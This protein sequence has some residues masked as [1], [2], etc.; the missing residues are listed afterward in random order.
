MANA[1]LAPQLLE[2]PDAV[3]APGSLTAASGGGISPW[4]NCPWVSG[5]RINPIN[6]TTIRA[7]TTV[8]AIAMLPPNQLV[9]D[10]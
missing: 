3:D 9:A 5:S 6:E 7:E 1:G 8:V 2:R 4:T 10:L